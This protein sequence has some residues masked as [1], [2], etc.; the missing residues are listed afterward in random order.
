MITTSGI[1]ASQRVSD[2]SVVY[3][4]LKDNSTTYYTPRVKLYIQ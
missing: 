3:H 2:G 1:S 4:T